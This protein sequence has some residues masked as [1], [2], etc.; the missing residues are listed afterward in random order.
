MR[1][2]QYRSDVYHN[3]IDEKNNCLIAIK[4][5]SQKGASG[6]TRSQ[7]AKTTNEGHQMF[8]ECLSSSLPI[9]LHTRGTHAGRC[10]KEAPSRWVPRDPTRQL[11][12]KFIK[13]YK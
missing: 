2:V 7:S 9:H 3:V 11:S 6:W 10:L 5:A 12:T 1:W 13:S 8:P 4:P